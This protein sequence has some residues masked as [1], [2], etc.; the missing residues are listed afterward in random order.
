MKLDANMAKDP[1][2]VQIPAMFWQCEDNIKISCT[3]KSMSK[4]DI[5]PP[6]ML[7]G[8]LYW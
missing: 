1:L 2:H 5:N 3:R 4:Y 6:L 7:P 8:I